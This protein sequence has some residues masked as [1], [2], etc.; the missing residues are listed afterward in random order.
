[1]AE[2]ID[3]QRL[4]ALEAEIAAL[5]GRQAAEDAVREASPQPPMPS[6]R[7][8]EL[9]DLHERAREARMKAA[10][11]EAERERRQAERERPKR[12]R[13]DREL[14]ALDDSIATEH[15]R[16]QAKLR[17]L[18]AERLELVHRPL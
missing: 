2:T 9:A 18:A 12:E 8:R 11:A 1:M 16:H 10:A 4:E 13:R 6:A 7:T 3:P 15:E 17:R 14:K 5:R